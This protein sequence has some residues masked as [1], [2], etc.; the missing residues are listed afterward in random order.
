MDPNEEVMV[1][2]ANPPANPPNVAAAAV[3]GATGGG[4]T[5]STGFLRRAAGF[6]RRVATVFL[7]GAALRAAFLAG[8]RVVFVFRDF[9]AAATLRRAGFLLRA[10][11]AFVFVLL[12][13]LAI[14]SSP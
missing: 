9:A 5:I 13:F 1:P 3:V 11:F 10:D 2:A 7:L 8:L 14:I 6:G 4:V 12:F